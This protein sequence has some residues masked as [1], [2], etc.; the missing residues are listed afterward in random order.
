[1]TAQI[2]FLLVFE[3]LG[4]TERKTTSGRFFFT[5]EPIFLAVSGVPLEGGAEITKSPI[6]SL[7][8]ASKPMQMYL[9]LIGKCVC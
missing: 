8:Y 2:E 7:K 4:P 1:M 3:Q 9:T 5:L 6:C